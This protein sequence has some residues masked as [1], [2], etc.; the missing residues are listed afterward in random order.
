MTLVMPTRPTFALP[1]DKTPG[2]LGWSRPRVR[3][4]QTTLHF[5][6]LDASIKAA[7]LDRLL[8]DDE[9]VFGE[10]VQLG[11]VGIEWSYPGSQGVYPTNAVEAVTYIKDVLQCTQEFVYEAAGIAARTYQGWV[12]GHIP[13]ESSLGRLWSLTHLIQAMEAV[14]PNITSWF[15]SSSTAKQLFLAGDVEGLARLEFRSRI[16]SFSPSRGHVLADDSM[17][18]DFDSEEQIS[19]EASAAF[20]ATE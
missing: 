8:E 2:L 16:S 7:L 6:Q 13:R 11:Y 14:N 18:Q 10:S 15:Q 17:F 19:D 1:Y 9:E 12:R 4:P 3:Q 20:L 5:Q